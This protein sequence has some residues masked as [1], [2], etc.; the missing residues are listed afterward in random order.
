MPA[1]KDG[2]LVIRGST[3]EKLHLGTLHVVNDGVL[4]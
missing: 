3:A 1:R 4:P 2:N